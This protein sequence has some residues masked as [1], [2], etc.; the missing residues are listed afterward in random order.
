M[1]AP[2]R[3][4]AP[5]AG[6]LLIVAAVATSTQP[7]PSLTTA[8]FVRLMTELAEPGGGFHSDNFTSNE[9]G[10]PDVAAELASRPPGGAYLGVGPEQNLSYIVAV[11]P[12][13]AFIVD[14]RR[15][16]VIQHLLFKA[17]F[18]LS[19]TRM[20]FLAR[21]FSVPKP[22]VAADASLEVLWRGIPAAGMG[23]NRQRYLTNRAEVE[24]HLTE[25]RG[26]ELSAD[27]LA[28]LD[29][30]YDAFATLGPAINY[31]GF[32]DRLTTGN[33]DFL[34]LSLAADAKG[35]RRSFLATDASF[36]YVRAMHQ[37][38]LIVPV[39]GDFGGP[40]TLRAI[41]D[42]LR[43]RGLA[44][45]AFY[46]SNV[47]QYL[48]GRSPSRYNDRNGGWENFYANL[49]ALPATASSVLVRAPSFSPL[50]GGRS[51]P[52]LCPI[53]PFLAA[54]KASRVTTQMQARQ[55]PQQ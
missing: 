15:Q 11:R 45:N 27:D 23:A 54:V 18:E 46:I 13:I 33:M 37:R 48:F 44:V 53:P 12:D 36:Q 4:A 7:P 6:V 49:A 5:L 50:R 1:R 8:E 55:C 38:N 52:A 41:G 28:A 31:A 10:F 24:A 34:K 43:A 25:T 35:V 16:A 47:E 29:Y 51:S 21:L 3:L 19:S 14:I 9:A 26:I 30:V 20:E 2:F 22:D 40:K 17:L 39:Q 42:D 32:Q